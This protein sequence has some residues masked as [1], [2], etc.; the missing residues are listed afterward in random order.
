MNVLS[1]SGSNLGLLIQLFGRC[2]IRTAGSDEY[3]L[4]NNP[5]YLGR[6]GSHQKYNMN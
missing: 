5:S 4:P 1:D 3:A 6:L 2:R